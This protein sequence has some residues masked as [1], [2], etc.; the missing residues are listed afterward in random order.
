MRVA[1]LGVSERIPHVGLNPP[2]A[3][4]RDTHTSSGSNAQEGLL[5]ASDDF[6]ALEASQEMQ[7]SAYTRAYIGSGHAY[8]VYNSM[9]LKRN[10]AH[11][12]CA[13]ASACAYACMPVF[14]CAKVRLCVVCVCVCVCVRI[15]GVV[16]Q[17]HSH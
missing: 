3:V 11:H 2:Q 6:K 8:T 10:T 1:G 9:L 16:W 14:A 13:F 5:I 12:V 4:D 15:T 17:R 7:V